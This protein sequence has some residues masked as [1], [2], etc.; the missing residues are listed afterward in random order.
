MSN[1]VGMT[2]ESK[3]NNKRVLHN[4][5][6]GVYED[7]TPVTEQTVNEVKKKVREIQSYIIEKTTHAVIPQT[8]GVL[9]NSGTGAEM[10]EAFVGYDEGVDN[11]VRLCYATDTFL[12]MEL[13][14]HLKGLTFGAMGTEN[15][16]VVVLPVNEADKEQPVKQKVTGVGTTK[17]PQEVDYGWGELGEKGVLD[18]LDDKVGK[19]YGSYA[20]L[21][22]LGETRLKKM[23]ELMLQVI[24][25]NKDELSK[26]SEFKKG[27]ALYG[28]IKG[29]LEAVK[30]II[31]HTSLVEGDNS[32]TWEMFDG[33]AVLNVYNKDAKGTIIKGTGNLSVPKDTPSYTVLRKFLDLIS[34]NI[35]Y[36]K[37]RKRAVI[38]GSTGEVKKETVNEP[39]TDTKKVTEIAPV[40]AQVSELSN[41]YYDIYL[42][43]A[44][45]WGKKDNKYKMLKSIIEELI[46]EC[47]IDG[48]SL[49]G[50]DD[51]EVVIDWV[52]D[53][54]SHT[55]ALTKK[56]TRVNV[57]EV[58][59][60][61]AIAYDTDY[62]E[63]VGVLIKDKLQN[64]NKKKEVSY[65]YV[66]MA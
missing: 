1:K 54:K 62:P 66:E 58:D 44:G 65:D 10:G 3:V 37:L 20:T 16:D 13:T 23:S 38:A 51:T 32:I 59:Y 42:A 25:S 5:V 36:T 39:V 31:P 9:V 29:L 14:R 60:D 21:S 63:L 19:V 2:F 34:S 50:I 8:Y 40:K 47:G 27:T 33:E 52:I 43:K 35:G 11:K 17:K 53:G 30:E 48:V 49:R 4:G 28:I 22:V 26:A 12:A 7:F 61:M 24:H 6:L 46:N 57:L 64:I 15:E 41:D 55:M 45:T 56:A 18:L